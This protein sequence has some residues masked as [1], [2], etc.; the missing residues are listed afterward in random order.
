MQTV[1]LTKAF[2]TAAKQAG[3][4]EDDVTDIVTFLAEN[5]LAGDPI[6]G[7]GGCR[8]VRIAG[9]GKGQKRRLQNN[10]VLLG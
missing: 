1:S 5:P 4:S 7:T 3:L 6:A 2:E 10:H 9:R 8:K